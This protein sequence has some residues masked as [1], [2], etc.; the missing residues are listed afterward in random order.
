MIL[1][2]RPGQGLE[3][4]TTPVDVFFQVLEG[5][6]EIQVGEETKEVPKGNIVLSPKNITHNVRIASEEEDAKVMVVK[7]P[8]P[9]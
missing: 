6:P 7:T 2:F 5:T 1:A 9:N 8:N 4:H 3:E